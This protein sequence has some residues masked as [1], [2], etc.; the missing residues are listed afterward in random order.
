L[1]VAFSRDGREL[2]SGTDN[3][4]IVAWDVTSGTEV[5]PPLEVKGQVFSLSFGSDGSALAAATDSPNA[6]L[7]PSIVAGEST[8][9]LAASLCDEVQGNLTAAEWSRFVGQAVGYQKVC[10][11]F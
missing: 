2:A 9:A 3:G 5:S 1:S 6:T 8:G 4:D 10:P 7:V 11:R